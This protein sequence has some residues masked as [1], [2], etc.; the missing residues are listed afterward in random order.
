MDYKVFS[1]LILAN[2]ADRNTAAN[3]SMRLPELKLTGEAD[4]VIY[5]TGGAFFIFSP[6]LQVIFGI[7][8]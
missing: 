6:P 3:S 7:K 2:L 1:C 5:G 4:A 8:G